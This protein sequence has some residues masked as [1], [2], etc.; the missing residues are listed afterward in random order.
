[1]SLRFVELM[2]VTFTHTYV[3]DLVFLC[4][5]IDSLGS[6]DP[7]QWFH[8]EELLRKGNLDSL[9]YTEDEISAVEAVRFVCHN[10]LMAVT[11]HGDFWRC[12]AT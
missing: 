4:A 11:K 9:L 8:L 1:M 5:S 3:H 6:Q 10:R 2:K 12:V 7:E